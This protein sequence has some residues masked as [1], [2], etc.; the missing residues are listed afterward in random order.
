LAGEY[1]KAIQPLKDALEVSE[2]FGMIWFSGLA[3]V[4]LGQT[5]LKTNPGQA[6]HHFEQGI[7]G[8]QQIQADPIF[9]EFLGGVLLVLKGNLRKGIDVLEVASPAFL[10][11]GSMWDYITAEQ[12]LSTVYLQL[13]LGEGPKTLPFIAKN[14]SFLIKSVFSSGE[15]A[16]YYL[17]NV[18]DTAKEIGATSLLGQA[19]LDLG[20][21]HKKKGRIDQARTCINES[22]RIFEDCETGIFLEQ[23]K[24][25]LVSL[26]SL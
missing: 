9:I 2:R 7:A 19:Y 11:K 12:M 25:V 6:V 24:E 10:K 17:Q 21:L 1:D 23:A 20:L 18:I 13:V 22:V 8:F 14:I 5:A 4:L 15:K 26:Q 3:H 16:A